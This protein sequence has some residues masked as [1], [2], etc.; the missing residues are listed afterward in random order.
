M[1]RCGISDCRVGSEIVVSFGFQ[2][3]SGA[4]REGLFRCKRFTG[5]YNPKLM[6]QRGA[7]FSSL[8]IFAILSARR[9]MDAVVLDTT[10]PCQA[11]R[12]SARFDPGF[13][14]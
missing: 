9:H 11:S 1:D 2:Q 5:N 10:G 7:I 13:I 3:N 8:P 6:S 12:P 4:L 14:S